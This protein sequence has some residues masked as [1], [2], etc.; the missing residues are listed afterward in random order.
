MNELIVVI[1]V[2]AIVSIATCFAIFYVKDALG[3]GLDI[4]KKSKSIK[5]APDGE[6]TSYT[7]DREDFEKGVCEESEIGTVTDHEE[8]KRR[9]EAAEKANPLK[10]RMGRLAEN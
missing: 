2:S 8:V 6:S 1:G 5:L 7:F 4:G 10:F 3:I 9:C